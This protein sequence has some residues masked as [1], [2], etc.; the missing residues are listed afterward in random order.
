MLKL[1][2]EAHSCPVMLHEPSS[3]TTTE[4]KKISHIGQCNCWEI[5]AAEV[6]VAVPTRDFGANLATPFEPLPVAPARPESV[7]AVPWLQLGL[8][9]P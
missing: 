3:A 5:S 1:S 9:E 8:K 4:E 6:A 2:L 7:T